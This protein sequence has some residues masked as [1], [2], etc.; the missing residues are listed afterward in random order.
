M[1]QQQISPATEPQ[2]QPQPRCILRL[3]EVERRTGYKRAHIY[4]L[5][6]DQKFPKSI[7]IGIRSVGWDSREIDSW[8][9]QRLEQYR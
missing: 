4:N 9:E 3:P 1:T 6:R 7:P 2:L 5:I 8:I